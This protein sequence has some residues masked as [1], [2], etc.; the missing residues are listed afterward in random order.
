MVALIT[1]KAVYRFS[2]IVLTRNIWLIHLVANNGLVKVEIVENIYFII[3]SNRINVE[4]SGGCFNHA[5]YHN[6][7]Y[8][9]KNKYINKNKNISEIKIRI[10]R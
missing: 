4:C 1:H 5:M 2:E 8:V 7:V 6:V 9:F 10:R 3:I